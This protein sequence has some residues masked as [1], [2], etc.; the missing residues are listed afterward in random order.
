MRV[1]AAIAAVPLL[2]G[3]AAGVLLVDYIPERLI[4]ALAATAMFGLIAAF[5]FLEEDLPVATFVTI[6]VAYAAAGMSMGT[7]GARASYAP[8]LL[9]WFESHTQEARGPVSLDGILREDAGAT[10]Y[11]ASTTMDVAA[12]VA[13]GSPPA[14]ASGGARIVIGGAVRAADLAQWRAGRHVRM[15][16]L[17]RLPTVFRDPGVQDDTRALARRGIV[18]IGSVKSASLVDVLNRGNRL[19]EVAAAVRARVRDVLS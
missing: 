9:R 2:A 16:A 5:G 10:E 19:E 15:S 1:P 13:S 11:G 3:S 6:A 4:L 14:M 8:S 7:A 17:L 18:L 12:V